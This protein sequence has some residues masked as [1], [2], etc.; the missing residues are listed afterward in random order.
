[1]EFKLKDVAVKLLDM[2]AEVGL[3]KMDPNIGAALDPELENVTKA[4]SRAVD[5]A[6]LRVGE[7]SVDAHV[8]A[9]KT[10]RAKKPDVKA[11]MDTKQV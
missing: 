5:L 7:L 11:A 8:E 6:R 9:V 2:R 10:E 1:M 4:I 3:M